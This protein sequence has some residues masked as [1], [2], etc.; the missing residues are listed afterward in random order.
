MLEMADVLSRH[1]EPGDL[2]RALAPSLRAVVPFD[3]LNFALY[4]P[5]RQVMKLHV[6]HSEDWPA[7]P[8]EVAVDEA[9]VGWVWERQQ[10]L[11]ID[12]LQRETRFERG[13]EWLRAHNLR[14]YCVVPL[15]SPQTRLGVLGFGSTRPCAF[16][17]RQVRYFQRVGDIV[18]LC[19]DKTMALS[20][21]AEEKRRVELLLAD[22]DAL[23]LSNSDVTQAFRKIS[24]MLRRVLRHEGAY[25]GLYDEEKKGFVRQEVDFPLGRG[26]L[27]A[28]PS[29][30]TGG[31]QGQAIA[32]RHTVTFSRDEIAAFR[33]EPFVGPVVQSLLDE[34]IKSLCC[35]PLIRP[36]GTLGALSLAS[37]RADAFLPEDVGL[38][39]QIGASA[40]H[41]RAIRQPT[42]SGERKGIELELY[43]ECLTA[44][45][46][47]GAAWSGRG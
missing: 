8:Q 16:S 7:V 42:C 38:L 35:V 46:A 26:L 20:A 4:E 5:A 29:N 21:L 34:G 13:I 11:T 27:S 37:T 47:R 36:G 23:R 39:N 14:S 12:D 31:P 22:V 3:F 25:F 19:V 9:A 18:A 43:P 15:T 30:T 41:Q 40:P 17:S 10:S 44:R 33:S 6:W 1:H 45:R 28:A 2:F 24:A 32:E